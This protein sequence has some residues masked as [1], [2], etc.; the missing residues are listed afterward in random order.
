MVRK[1]WKICVLL[2]AALVLG[3]CGGDAASH[4]VSFVG[5]VYNVATG[6]KLSSGQYTM[7]IRVGTSRR[8]CEVDEDGRFSCGAISALDDYSVEVQSAG[9]RPFISHNA[10]EGVPEDLVL[11]D[12]LLSKGTKRVLFYNCY[13]SPDNLVGPEV[14]L[15]IRG[16]SNTTLSGSARVSPLALSTLSD[17]TDEDTLPGVGQQVWE[18][19]QD[20]LGTRLAFDFSNGTLV[21][22][23]GQLLA[24]V[25]YQ[26]S[27]YNVPGYVP[28]QQNFN[29]ATG[30]FTINLTSAATLPLE[31]ISYTPA[32]SATPS[33]N[34]ALDIQ[35]NQPVILV[36]PS[37]AASSIDLGAE[38]AFLRLR[39]TRLAGNFT[40][41]LLPTTGP[42][43]V[44]WG[45]LSS[46]QV[47][48]ASNPSESETLASLG[49]SSRTVTV[50]P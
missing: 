13:L 45:F 22:P 39:W 30:P 35:F 27:V 43:S 32:S 48:P 10:R 26:I 50:A 40:G 34:G 19:D 14:T 29:A 7:F 9:F 23:A 46:I 25:P 2:G 49:V 41:G 6:Q 20:L 16:G 11:A 37:S 42:T 38:G 8:E 18:N 1:T 47:A 24:G 5:E 36:D 21:I 31:F 44:T 4:K 12:E 33:A 15:Q 17:E 28:T 3:A